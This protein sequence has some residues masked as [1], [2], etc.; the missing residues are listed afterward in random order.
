MYVWYG[1][2]WYLFDSVSFRFKG[3]S[4]RS[5]RSSKGS[6][7]SNDRLA[8]AAPVLTVQF[9]GEGLGIRSHVAG[10][11]TKH[12]QTLPWKDLTTGI[13]RNIIPHMIARYK[14]GYLLLASQIRFKLVRRVWGVVARSLECPQLSGDSY[15]FT[16][17]LVR[18]VVQPSSLG[19][20][21]LHR[22]IV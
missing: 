22:C 19:V 21:L 20:L 14:G 3:A 15:L 11:N 16:R 5:S 17:E 10:G 7:V 13:T 1:T 12:G 18:F 8:T 6:R 4:S 2:F 9:V